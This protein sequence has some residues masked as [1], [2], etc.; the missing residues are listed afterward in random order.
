MTTDELIKYA[1]YAVESALRY[2]EIGKDGQREADIQLAMTYALIA[3]A[4][5][6]R[7]GNIAYDKAQAGHYGDE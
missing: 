7:I 2:Q 1:E 5:E 4:N 3:I 6:L